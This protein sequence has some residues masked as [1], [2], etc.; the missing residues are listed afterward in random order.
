MRRI[1]AL[2]LLALLVAACSGRASDTRPTTAGDSESTTTSTTVGAVVGIPPQLA[3]HQ[4]RDVQVGDR[5]MSLAIADSPTLRATGLMDVTDLGDL[6]G[7]LFY[8]RHH[9]TGGFWMK[10]TVIP[11]DIVWFLEDGS[12]AGRASM[13]PCPPDASDCPTF[14]P[15]EGIDYRLAIEA[16]PGDLDWIDKST[17]IVYED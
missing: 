14:D 17:V 3:D 4:V 7:M 12:Y 13:D 11:L 6:D 1:V 9:A 2:F 5:T 15:G 8:W 10:D 16:N